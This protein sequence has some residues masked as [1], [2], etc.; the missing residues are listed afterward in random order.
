M[1][2]GWQV[3]MPEVEALHSPSILVP[4]PGPDSAPDALDVFVYL[5]PE[6]NGVAVES[7][8]LKV[9]RECRGRES[10]IDLVYMANVPGS[11]IVRRRI[12]ER[13][14]SLRLQ[15]DR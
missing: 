4:Y 11:H 6:T 1:S 13:H 3:R 2:N 9:V 5:R 14:Y 12:V 15:R 10:D 8:V 7:T